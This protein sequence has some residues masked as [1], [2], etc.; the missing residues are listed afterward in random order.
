[1]DS[2]KNQIRDEIQKTLKRY[3]M[4]LKKKIDLYRDTLH[5]KEDIYEE[6]RLLV[7]QT[8]E[9]SNIINLEAI[10][11]SLEALKVILENFNDREIEFTGR[12]KE[13][14]LIENEIKIVCKDH[15][16]RSFLLVGEQSLGLSR[17]R[18]FA[19]RA[20]WPARG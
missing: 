4:K 17:H 8:L 10:E 16:S 3:E 14:N 2:K 9:T 5:T 12:E 11:I 7:E 18:H 19:E 13:Q 20:R 1:M 15:V 6:S